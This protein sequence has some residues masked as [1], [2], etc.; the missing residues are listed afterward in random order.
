MPACRTTARS[1]VGPDVQ[2]VLLLDRGQ[3]LGELPDR[4]HEALDLLQR[5]RPHRLARHPPAQRRARVPLL[6]RLPAR[7]PGWIPTAVR[8]QIDRRTA[9]LFQIAGPTSLETLERRPARACATSASCASA[10]RRSTARPRSR[11]SACPATSPTSCAG[12]SRR[13]RRSTTRLRGGRALGIQRLGWR[14]LSRQPRRGRLPADD[15]DLL[16]LRLPR[17]RLHRVPRAIG[18]TPPS[19]V[20]RQVDPADARARLR[21]PV[22]LGVGR[23]VKFDHDFTGPRRARGRG[24]GPRRTVGDA[25]LEPARTSSTSTPRC[26]SRARSTR[27]IDLPTSAAV[28]LGHE[29]PR[30]PRPQATAGRR[31]LLGHD[32]QLL[33]PAGDVA[34]RARP[35]TRRR[36]GNEVVVQLGRP[37]RAHQGRPRHRRALPVPQRG[38]QQRVDVAAL[39]AR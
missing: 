35:S 20:V 24:R 8:R 10:T 39:P 19:D 33:L 21:N 6:R 28:E 4:E 1:S 7:P 15:L 31:L 38:P 25:A 14:H 27:P 30:G 5:R 17:P 9:Y 29:R 16:E 37:R 18:F 13:A 36:L 32:L 3:Q 22:E 11:G 12:R 2:G 34:R 23:A 26:C